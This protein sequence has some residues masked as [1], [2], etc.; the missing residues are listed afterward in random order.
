[1]PDPSVT[2]TTTMELRRLEVEPHT[3]KASDG[4]FACDTPKAQ[5]GRATIAKARFSG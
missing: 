1:M 4:A 2:Y 5:F 3:T